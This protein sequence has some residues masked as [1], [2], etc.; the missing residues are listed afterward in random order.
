MKTQPKINQKSFKDNIDKHD[1]ENNVIAM[2][3]LQN[4]SLN[5][6]K[7]FNHQN[8]C[9]QTTDETDSLWLPPSTTLF[10]HPKKEHPFHPWL[11]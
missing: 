8:T 9:R 10:S 2:L 3:K 11:I 6:F 1:Y 7:E 5:F 4:T